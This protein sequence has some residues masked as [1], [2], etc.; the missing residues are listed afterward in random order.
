VQIYILALNRTDSVT[1]GFLPAAERLG[2]AVTVLTDALEQ[3]E[4]GGGRPGKA[5]A[6]REEETGAQGAVTGARQDVTGAR[7]VR[8]D[9]RNV[10]AVVGCISDLG[11][12]DAVFSNSDHLQVQTALAAGYFGL[13]AKDWTA[14]LRTK[15]K[16]LMRRHLARAGLDAVDSVEIP[17]GADPASIPRLPYPC[18]VKPREGVASEDVFL[19]R[20]AYDLGARVSQIRRR[21]PAD[22]LVVEEFLDGPLHTLETVGS[23]A[24]TRVLGGFRTR[25]S[26]PPYFVEH[27]LDW[28]PDL[29]ST[30]I[31]DVLN[32]MAA[33]GVGLGACHTEFVLQGD[34][35]RLVEVNYRIIGDHCDLLLA[36]LLDEPVFELVLRA[37]LGEDVAATAPHAPP[38][39]PAARARRHARVEYVC[40]QAGGTLRTAPYSQDLDGDKVA[41]RY[42]LLRP[43]GSPI[44][45]THSNRDYLGAIRAIGEDRPAVDRAVE[46]FLAGHTWEVR[47]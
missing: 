29:P 12:P 22:A 33:L 47:P 30:V 23:A 39:S 34:R 36:E 3:Y 6:A 43:V 37:H 45:L 5:T 46:E 44:E 8:C 16:A 40:A 7:V 24:G 1:E 19:V 38:P 13:P 25:I 14:A 21:R 41:L 20:D 18:V 31:G 28:H 10:S 9:V 2:A 27:G 42:R 32:Q 35:V 17:P 26:P 4:R 15:N 11:R